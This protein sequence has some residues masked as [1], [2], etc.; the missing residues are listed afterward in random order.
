MDEFLTKGQCIDYIRSHAEGIAEGLLEPQ[1]YMWFQY[2]DD[3]GFDSTM[4]ND[5]DVRDQVNEVVKQAIAKALQNL[6]EE[7]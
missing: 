4:M 2:D 7:A 1:A 6:K 3:E 5:H